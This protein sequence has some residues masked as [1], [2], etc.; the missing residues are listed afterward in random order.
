MGP[1]Q[2]AE[3]RNFFA[4]FEPR[5][6]D[7]VA[8]MYGRLLEAVP[9]ARQLFKGD[10]QEQQRRYLHMLQE[11]VKLTRSRQLWPVQASTGTSTIPA[12]D[13]MASV[14]GAIGVRREHFDKMKEVLAQCFREESP[15]EFTPAAEEG[16]SFIFDVVAMAATNTAGVTAEKLARK[17]KLP[18]SDEIEAFSPGSGSREQHFWEWFAGEEELLFNF[19]RDRDRASGLLEA[20]LGRVWSGLTFEF[21]PVSNGV[22]DFVISAGG[23]EAAFPAVEALAAAA[24][25]L[26]RWNVVKFRPRH[27]PIVQRSFGGKT[28]DPG[29]VQFSVL[30]DG[31][32]LGLYLYIDGYS[33]EERAVWDQIGYLLLDEALGEFDA[34]TKVGLIE[35]FPSDVQHEGKRFP[36][37]R[38]PQIF[39]E[40]YASLRQAH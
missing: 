4:S 10:F 14:H 26:P 25:A 34:G 28:V 22:R 18:H 16:L 38:L 27:D 6:P 23:I 36:L 33:E 39:D 17:N 29:D 40:E 13:K 11:L 5:L 32:E 8:L 20:A 15:H 21:G 31:Q 24:P 30:S 3:L 37:L 2:L 19:E 35:F 7:A 9:E 12:V 1:E